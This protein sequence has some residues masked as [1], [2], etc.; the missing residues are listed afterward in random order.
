MGI[1]ESR[2]RTHIKNRQ[3]ENE[4]TNFTSVSQFERAK[5][6]EDGLFTIRCRDTPIE[7]IYETAHSDTTVVC[8]HGAKQKKITLPWHIGRQVLSGLGAN[9][10]SVSDPALA[11][12]NRLSLGW[13]AGTAAVPNLQA[14]IARVI[15]Q[16]Q[17]ITSTDHLVFFGGSGG[18]FATLD[19]SRRFVNSLALPMNPQTSIGRYEKAAV[20]NYMK[21]AWP[22]FKGLLTLPKSVAHDQVMAYGARHNNTVAYLQ[23]DRDSFHIENHMIP[24]FDRLNE[25]QGL[26]SYT[27]AWGAP[28]TS[29]HTKPP[30]SLVKE[31]L[32]QLV[33]VSG[34]WPSGLMR[35][36][37]KH[38]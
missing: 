16:V 21:L 36:G 32:G 35:A 22:G 17:R 5:S 15:R 25:S 14:Y 18:G 23:N 20:N 12:D 37:F 19:M 38:Q 2:F 7:F 24:F 26:W 3:N 13:H 1:M 8:F 9:W 33:S 31:V 27:D 4:A 30:G 34:D 29:G 11:Q 6:L 10:L 28:E